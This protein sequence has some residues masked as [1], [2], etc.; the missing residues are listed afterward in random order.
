MQTRIAY[1]LALLVA[2][3]ERPVGLPAPGDLTVHEWGTFTTVAGQDGLAID[4][5]PLGGPTDLPC[6]VEHFQNRRDVKIAP[7]QPARTGERV[8]A[9]AGGLRDRQVE[10]MGQG[11]DGD[12]RALLL[13]HAPHG[14][15]R[16][17]AVPAWAHD[18]VVPGRL[19]RTT[20]RQQGLVSKRALGEL[21]RVA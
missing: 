5:L 2:S 13:L 15:Q 9:G 4:W 8:F 16:A 12:A 18:G 10:S 7:N 6:F 17:S 11:A 19:G 1:V 14:R 3:A 21:D 20:V